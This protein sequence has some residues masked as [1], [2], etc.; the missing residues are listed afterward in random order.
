MLPGVV[1]AVTGRCRIL[2]DSGIR[3]AVDVLCALALG[4]MGMLLDGFVLCGLVVNGADVSSL[5]TC[6]GDR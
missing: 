2:R 4:A 6:R 5:V 1:D 3:S